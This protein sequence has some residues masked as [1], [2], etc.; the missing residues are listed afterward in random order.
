MA[1]AIRALARYGLGMKRVPT[2]FLPWLARPGLHCALVLSNVEARFKVG[3]NQG[4][5]ALDVRQY[6]ADGRL[7]HRHELSLRDATD[8]VELPLQAAAGGY[9]IVTVNGDRIHSDLYVT[10]SDGDSYTA[11]HGRGEWIEQY[12]LRGRLLQAMA[13]GIV[14]LC[15]RT[16]SAFTRHQ[17]VYVGPESRSHLLVLNLSDI[18][19]H[20]RA[21][22]TREDEGD[23]A[24][25]LV[26]PPLG[27]RLLDVGDLVGGVGAEL[28]VWRMT[29]TGNAWF[30]L[31]LLG[32]GPLDLAGPVSLMHVK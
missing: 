19:N 20:V 17:Y 30:N 24:R 11:T 12:P 7:A 10:V 14:G 8:V 29:L 26:I 22:A 18:P 31:Y 3:W 32:A 2:Y 16:V 1:T 6:D 21:S 9:G 5:Y 25:T 27:A 4:P 13:R 28:R 15:G 23:R